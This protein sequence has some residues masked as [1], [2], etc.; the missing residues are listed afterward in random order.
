[1]FV[2]QAWSANRSPEQVFHLLETLYSEFDAIAKKR[3]VFK[4]ET[5]G[6]CYVAVAGLP[7]PRKSHA[8]VMARFA[9]DCID[10][11]K[12]LSGEL[13]QM[14]GSVSGPR[15]NSGARKGEESLVV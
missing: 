8:L 14:L 15:A 3:G 2:L 5:I 12:E 10:K 4:V 6:D 1:L 9:S 7:T 13:E 11:M